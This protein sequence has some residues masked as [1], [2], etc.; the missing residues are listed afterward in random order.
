[1]IKQDKSNGGNMQK[2]EW[3]YRIIKDDLN[4]QIK[5]IERHE[6]VSVSRER[7]KFL[8]SESTADQIFY[9][10]NNLK[11]LLPV[12][13]DRRSGYHQWHQA[14]EISFPAEVSDIYLI[15]RSLSSKNHW[16]SRDEYSW[17]HFLDELI[18]PDN[19]IKLIDVD[20]EIH[21]YKMSDVEVEFSYDSFSGYHNSS[22]AIRDQNPDKINKMRK[23]LDLLDEDSNDY[24]T[25]LKKYFLRKK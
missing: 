13:K 11:I 16:L 24:V 21:L 2:L 23:Q 10:K 19:Q 8:I 3:E 9:F 7:I 20:R 17:S 25:T 1:M 5:E 6:R 22:I 14:F 12:R 4:T 15:L 18:L